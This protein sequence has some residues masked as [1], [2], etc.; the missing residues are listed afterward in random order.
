MRRPRGSLLSTWLTVAML[1]VSSSLATAIQPG[2]AL[3]QG[4]EPQRVSLKESDLRPGFKQDKDKTG[5]REPIQGITVYEAD[6]VRDRNG[7]N[8]NSG[9]IEVKNLVART[10][11][12]QQAKEQFASSRQALL[13][14]DPKWTESAVAKLGDQSTGLTAYGSM[15][16]GSGVAHLFLFQKGPMVAG[17]TVAGLEKVTK[18]AEAEALA[19]IVLRRIDPQYASAR[20]PTTTRTQNTQAS[21][22]SGS[23]GSSSSSRPTFTT[24]AGSSTAAQANQQGSGTRVRVA[25]TDGQRL[26]LRAEPSTSARI[27]THFQP[28]TVLEVIGPDRQA[29]GRTWKNVRGP[30]NATGWVAGD[31]TAAVTAS[32]PGESAPNR[33]APL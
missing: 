10:T 18:M 2:V 27:V 24:P 12:E 19:A 23:S 13:A 1:V 8:L 9:P 4:T 20:A 32:A 3:A 22:S 25:N 16:G 33:E 30:G 15:E 7:D 28:G 31:Y 5:T 21:G 26:R 11:S 14:A 17:V 6:F 29:E